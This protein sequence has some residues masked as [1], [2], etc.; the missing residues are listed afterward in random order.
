MAEVEKLIVE[1]DAKVD[2]YIRDM[3]KSKQKN[4]GFGKSS[5]KMGNAVVAAGKVATAAIV[6]I[7]AA[8]TAMIVTASKSQQELEAMARQA[9]TSTGEF[10]SL[11]FA[12]KQYGVEAENIADISKDI[13]DR[14]GEFAAAGT[15]TFQD[16]ADVM[17]MSTEAAQALAVEWQNL[18]SDQV[19]GNMVSMME[20]AG[21]TG[22]EMTFVLESMGNDLSKLAP[23][24][25]DNSAKLLEMRKRYDEVNG[26]LQITQNQALALR[27]AA[28]TFDLMTSSIGKAGTAISATLAPVFDDFFNDVIKVVPDATQVIVDF[29]NSFLD[30]EN[31]TSIVAV[32]KEMIA[33]KERILELEKSISSEQGSGGRSGRGQRVSLDNEQE[34]LE[35]LEQQLEVLKEQKKE[36]EDAQ[37]IQGGQIGGATGGGGGDGGVGSPADIERIKARLEAFEDSEKTQLELLEERFRKES[38]LIANNIK[39]HE[40]KQEMLKEL[41]E[42]YLES[43]RELALSEKERL[44]EERDADIDEQ[45]ALYEGELISYQEFLKRKK[46]IDDSFRKA[47]ETLDKIKVKKDGVSAKQGIAVAKAA[48]RELF[49]DNKAVN[50]GLIVADTAA[51]IMSEYKTGGWAGAALAAVTGALQLAANESASVGG[52]SVATPGSGGATITNQ[53]SDFV[54]ETSSLDVVDQDFDIGTRDIKITISDES[55]KTFVETIGQELEVARNEG[56]V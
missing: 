42:E 50:A 31:I 49:E 38:E 15:G 9:K 36:M 18:S 29:I 26:S 2:G 43:K 53:Q 54:P 20:E 23:L 27:E 55:G 35:K 11:A 33:S 25:A 19:I 32:E 6:G 13:S 30:A 51:T 45:R 17:G 16:F 37:R 12:T 5:L 1:L 24:F 40:V 39:D 46:K 47:E 3:E 28:T 44:E 22:N 10:E 56:R 41:D 14:L 34:R 4:E 8:L 7:G 21:A 52:G 48:N